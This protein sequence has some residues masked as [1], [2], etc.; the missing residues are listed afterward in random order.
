MPGFSFYSMGYDP[1][2]SLFILILKRSPM[3]PELTFMSL[4][5]IPII[6]WT[7]PSFW[8]QDVPGSSV[9]SLPPTWKWPFLRDSLIPF[10]RQWYLGENWALVVYSLLDSQ[11]ILLSQRTSL[12]RLAKLNG[13]LALD[14]C[15]IHW[16]VVAVRP[17]E[18]IKLGSMC[19]SNPLTLLYARPHL[20]LRLSIHI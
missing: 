4:W 6:L 3:W 12:R 19:T 13:A 2:V 1:L 5:N 8:L 16:G 18:Q 11:L 17:Y 9:L 14:G 15:N 7:I 10:S 20:F